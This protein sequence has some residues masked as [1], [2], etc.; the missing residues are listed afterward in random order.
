MPQFSVITSV[1]NGEA[2]LEE[3]INSILSQ[4]FQ[5]FEYI[6]LNNGSTDGTREIL[7]RYSDSRLRIVHQDNLGIVRSLN[8]GVSL[9]RSD[10]IAR[11]DADDYVY[12]Q[13]LEKHYEFLSQ[14][15]DIVLCGSRFEELFNGKLYP[16]VFPFVE[17]DY[18]IRKSLCFMNPISH[19]FTIIRKPSF[20]KV[21]GYDPNFIIA[22]DY[23]LWIRLLGKGKGHTLNQILGVCRRHDSSFSTKKER[24][25]IK[26][27]F[28]VQWK[29]YT[30]LG[31]DCWKMVQSLSKRGIAWF[32]PPE[33]RSFLRSRV[34]K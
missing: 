17:H 1:H 28:Q 30:R 26:E 9:C 12:P 3:C 19:S 5:E 10:L 31:G 25:M 24:T 29:A 27:S 34:R 8:K 21:G 15:K 16:Q 14:N 18:E 7:D 32:V 6:I 4:T 23:D 22:H 20:L 2:F 11:L 33:L 13:W